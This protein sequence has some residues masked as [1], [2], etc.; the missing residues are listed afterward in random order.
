MKKQQKNS[1]KKEKG[2]FLSR[3]L[4]AAAPRMTIECAERYALLLCGCKKIA[5]YSP[6]ETVIATAACRVRVRGAKLCISFAGE[7]KILL[8]GTISAI[9]FE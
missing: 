1:G 7:G 6:E 4:A 8:S 5:S 2:S 9:E 3:T